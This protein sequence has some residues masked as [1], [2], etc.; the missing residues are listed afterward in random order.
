LIK[1]AHART[2]LGGKGKSEEEKQKEREEAG[3]E[4]SEDAPKEKTASLNQKE[5]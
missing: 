4:R 1:E 3:E 5:T 2:E